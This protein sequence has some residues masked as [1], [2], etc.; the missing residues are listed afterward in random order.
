MIYL[1]KN[2]LLIMKKLLEDRMDE[3][4]R[5]KYK[6]VKQHLEDEICG[7]LFNKICGRIAHNALYG[8]EKNK[9]TIH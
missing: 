2:E 8:E 7:K 1:D 5:I 4:E 9:W 3:L 6:N